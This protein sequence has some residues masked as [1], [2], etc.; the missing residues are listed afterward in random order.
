MANNVSLISSEIKKSLERDISVIESLDFGVIGI[1]DTKQKMGYEQVVKLINKTALSDKGSLDKEQ[2]QYYIDL[3]RGHDEGIKITQIFSDNSQPKIIISKKKHS[4]V[5]F[6]TIN[7]GFIEGLIQ[8]YSVP[9]V[10]FELLDEQGNKIYSI[11]NGDL[12]LKQTDVVIVAGSNWYLRSYIDYNHIKK[13][14]EGIN[15]DITKYMTICAFITLVISLVILN[16]Y[17]NPLSKLM[18]LVDNLASRD[19]DLTQRID[20]NRQDE[21]GHISNSV[22]CFIDNLQALFTNISSSNVAL[23]DAREEL[24]VQIGRNVS[25]VTRYNKQS[26]SLSDAINDIRQSSLDIQ[27]QAHQAIE[28]AQQVTSRVSQAALKGEIA[29]NIVVGLGENTEQISSSL[30]VMDTVSQGISSILSSIQKI[31]DQTDLLAL[32]ASIEAARAGESGKGFAVV[33]E[34]V[35]ILASKTRSS[36]IEIAEFLI[37]FSDSSEQLMGQMTLVLK[38][39]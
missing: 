9:G 17:L 5:D 11:E 14:I 1:R 25:T 8:R 10:Y 3:A 37:Q 36:T 21:I 20:L 2:S 16:F 34:E 24:D 23:N 38:S 39:S 35:R 13:V 4:V 28:L 27:Q 22:N 26:E 30:G 18:A 32:N 6:F 33:A 29:E 15:K 12:D 31:A 7:M 19:V